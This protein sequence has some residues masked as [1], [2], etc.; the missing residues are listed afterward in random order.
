MSTEAERIF[1]GYADGRGRYSITDQR[2]SLGDDFIEAIEFLKSWALQ[3][4]VNGPGSEIE[5]VEQLAESRTGRTIGT[6]DAQA[7]LLRLQ[8]DKPGPVQWRLPRLARAEDSLQ[9]PGWTVD[10]SLADDLLGTT[11][12]APIDRQTTQAR[13]CDRDEWLAKNSTAKTYYRRRKKP[14]PTAAKTKKSLA[15]RFYQLRTGKALTRPYLL[16]TGR[17]ADDRC[18]WCG[19]GAVQTRDHLFKI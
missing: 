7:A 11:S 4:L 17:R 3:A 1:S 19:S 10:K 14:D 12:L 9:R 18:W 2:A 8:D 6:P 16:K 5:K 15:P 13:S